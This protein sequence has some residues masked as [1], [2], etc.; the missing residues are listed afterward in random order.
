VTDSNIAFV[1]QVEFQPEYLS[2]ATL[3]DEPSGLTCSVAVGRRWA[4]GR[5]GSVVGYP[6]FEL[7]AAAVR[8]GT[9]D[10]LLVPAA[11][12][13]IRR[14]FFDPALRAVETFLAQLPDMVFAVPP[15]RP[16]GRF[17]MV[18]HHPATT[19][20]V[21]QL[22]YD[23]AAVTPSTSNSAACRDA[24]EYPGVV[25]AVTNRIAADHYHMRAVTVLSAG[26]PMGFVVFARKK[27]S[28]D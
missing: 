28:Y 8:S 21:E 26:T 2:I 11:Y 10:A 6:S 9:H 18:F 5:A 13:D 27:D 23:V 3:A 25:G 7:A 24:L 4:H 20:L 1:E 12:P 15:G 16:A 22:P 17:D 14:F 19:A